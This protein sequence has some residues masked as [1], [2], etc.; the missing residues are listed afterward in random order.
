MK[1]SP[2]LLDELRTTTRRAL[3]AAAGDVI[4]ELDL[5]GLLVDTG[6]GGSG[7]GEREMVLVANEL[8]SALSPSAFLPTA[9]IASTFL[10]H[11]DTA[12]AA[13]LLAAV[14]GGTSRCAVALAGA[15]TTAV[16]ATSTADGEWSVSGSTAALISPSQSDVLLTVASTGDG[17]ALFAVA[18][19]HAGVTPA[20]QLDS[21]RGLVDVTL[22][23]SPARQLASPTAT[24][25]GSAAAYRRSLLAVAGEQVGV[26]RA[27]LETAVEY[28]KTR[29]QFGSPIGSY[30][31][32]KHRCTD[33]LLN[34]E[35]ADSVV[36]QA[37][38]GGALDDAELAFVVAA[39]AAVVA[40]ESCIHIHGGIGFTWEHS[41]HRYLRRA[42]VNASLLGP[43]ALH[44]N[45][46]AVSAGL[47]GA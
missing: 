31:A 20:D 29:T 25:T 46:I 17:A 3:R 43:S 28:A 24:A 10:S 32:I 23:Q 40:A 37:A 9:V 35:L 26:A 1:L 42:Q 6:S 36:A 39:R 18:I 19:E 5:A 41:A 11:A 12:A 16:E 4:E 2:E 44:R 47:T 22:V 45:A 30:Q 33:V 8:G 38:D 21:D 34:I 7:L 13:D 27:C 15:D 14:V